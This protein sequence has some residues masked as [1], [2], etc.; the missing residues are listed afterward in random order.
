MANQSEILRRV[1]FAKAAVIFVKGNIENPMHLIFNA[2]MSP[3]RMGKVLN[4]TIQ[5]QKIVASLDTGLLTLDAA[6]SFD[7]PDSLQ[8]RPT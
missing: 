6:L 4:A 8:P 3:H 2:P 5:T 7:H 1:V